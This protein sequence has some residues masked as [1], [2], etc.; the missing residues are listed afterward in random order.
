MEKCPLFGSPFSEVL[1]CSAVI[2]VYVKRFN[3]VERERERDR[4]RL[5]MS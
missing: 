4:E 2:I 5:E 1:L 3:N